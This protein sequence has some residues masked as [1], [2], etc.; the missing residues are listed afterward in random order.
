MLSEKEQLYKSIFDGYVKAFKSKSK[1]KCQEEANKIWT[2][3][4]YKCKTTS[5]INIAVDKKLKDLKQIE[6]RKKASVLSFWSKLPN[7]PS[8]EVVVE[9]AEVEICEDDVIIVSEEVSSSQ[10]NLSK[11]PAKQAPKQEQIEREIL[12]LQKDISYLSEKR[13]TNLLSEDDYQILGVKKKLLIEKNQELLIRKKATECQKATRLKRK[14]GIDDLDPETRK[15][16]CGKSDSSKGRPEIYDQ[17]DLI[18]TI[19]D[20]ALKGSATDDR[21]RTEIIRT[22]KTLDDLV[23]ELTKYG[24]HLSRS[25]VYLRLLP[26]RSLSTEGKRH[27]KTAPVKLIRAQNSEHKSHPDSNFA[28][29]SISAL[30]ELAGILGPREV[31]FHSQDDKARVPIGLTAATSATRHKRTYNKVGTAAGAAT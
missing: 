23:D 24:F 26:S 2:E 17:D 13:N 27:T 19:T 29:A 21:R 4:K 7:T 9:S 5:E 25:A 10:E 3:I 1:Q 6:L 15:K 20:I 14:R 16:V 30:E 18:K 8:K 31:T 28:R 22:V 12:V 11:T